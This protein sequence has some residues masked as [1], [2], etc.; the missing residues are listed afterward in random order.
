VPA[1]ITPTA[2]VRASF[3]AAMEE[4]KAEARGTSD[5]HSGLGQ[6]IRTFGPNW[7]E[8]AAFAE[9]VAWLLDLQLEETPRPDGWVPATTLWYVEGDEYLGRLNVRHRLTPVLLELGGHIGYDVRRSARRRGHATAML[10]GGLAV[11][12]GMGIDR[13]LITCD[14]DNVGSRR[15]IEINGGV[16]EDERDGKLRFWVPTRRDAA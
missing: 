12:A 14:V 2:R 13:A 16:F 6:E 5:D 11:A 1:L 8:P 10:A 9:Y 15:V 7:R 4:F 3:I